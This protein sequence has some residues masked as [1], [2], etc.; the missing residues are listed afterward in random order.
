MISMQSIGKPGSVRA[1]MEEEVQKAF[2]EVLLA[3]PEFTFWEACTELVKKGEIVGEATENVNVHTWLHQIFQRAKI[4]AN[5]D[6]VNKD[7]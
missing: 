1:E 7:M 2:D 3:N 4:K 6:R 5:S